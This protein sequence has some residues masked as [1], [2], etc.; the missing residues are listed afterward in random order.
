MSE[1][2][3]QEKDFAPNMNPE[4]R[5]DLQDYKSK[6]KESANTNTC[7]ECGKAFSSKEELAVHYNKDH[8]DSL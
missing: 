1:N 5:P 7:R 4:E 6:D 2:K 8:A 3:K